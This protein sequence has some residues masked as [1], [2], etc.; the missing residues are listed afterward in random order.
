M[1]EPDQD[2][3]SS[4][5]RGLRNHRPRN[6]KIKALA[7]KSAK[8]LA[9]K[10]AEI[11]KK[12]A[13]IKL[14]KETTR[15]LEVDN[16]VLQS[17]LDGAQQTIHNILSGQHFRPAFAEAPSFSHFPHERSVVADPAPGLNA[18]AR[19]WHQPQ[20]DRQRVSD[21]L[22]DHPAGHTYSRGRGSRS[23]YSSPSSQDR[24]SGP[25]RSQ[26]SSS[27]TPEQASQNRSAGPPHGRGSLHGRAHR[28]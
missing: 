20:Q 24:R 22:G 8:I 21:R 1:S 16:A 7:D 13:E 10:D 2:E 6:E 9:L 5:A 17:K 12:D 4:A 23:G 15:K 25:G 19:A 14:L 3:T 28:D 27:G 11:A 26:G 18:A